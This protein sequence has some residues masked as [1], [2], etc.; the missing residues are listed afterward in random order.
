MSCNRDSNPNAT[1]YNNVGLVIFSSGSMAQSLRLANG[2]VQKQIS[3]TKRNAKLPNNKLN[4]GIV[5]S[6]Y[7]GCAPMKSV[8]VKLIFHPP[9]SA[10][11]PNVLV[12]SDSL[13]S[14]M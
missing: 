5:W 3:S 8:D 2:L 12:D 6:W 9:F 11:V 13:S 1:K 7:L 14:S 10:V 4:L